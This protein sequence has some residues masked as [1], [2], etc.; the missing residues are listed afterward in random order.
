M[1]SFQSK[2]FGELT[3]QELYIILALRAVVFVVEQNCPYQDV[4]GKDEHAYHL[5]GYE[6]T[7]LV[8]YARVLP[9]G[10]AY[11]D[12]AS[13]GRIVTAPNHRTKGYG[14]VLVEQAIQLCKTTFSSVPI[15]ISAQAHL[16]NFYKTHGFIATGE[17][18]LEDDIPHIG[19]VLRD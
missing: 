19:M 7:T 15:K 18:Y 14:Y 6:N 12:Y 13:I 10:T 11:T 2:T 4:D 5:L 3:L 8:A 1:L 17:A 9:K 16:E